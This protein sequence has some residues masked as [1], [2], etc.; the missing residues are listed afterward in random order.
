MDSNE[1]EEDEEFFDVDDDNI[2]E[3]LNESIN[4]FQQAKV[5][6]AVQLKSKN[7]STVDF[8]IDRR[9]FKNQENAIKFLKKDPENRRFKSFKSFEEAYAFSYE[10]NEFTQ[11]SS[12][13]M[14]T[15]ESNNAIKAENSQNRG[16]SSQDAEKLPFSAPKKPEMNELRSL[17][18]KNIIETVREKVLSNPRFL[19]SAGDTPTLVQVNKYTFLHY[20]YKLYYF[21]YINCLKCKF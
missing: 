4:T 20:T 19:I 18:E 6:Y 21:L 13:Q 15:A 1:I 11:Y 10:C 7:S 5:F 3:N 8:S 14:K 12:Y 17:I 16:S 2:N 9:I